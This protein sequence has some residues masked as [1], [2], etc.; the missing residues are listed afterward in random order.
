[1]S[2]WTATTKHAL[3][4]RWKVVDGGHNMHGFP[5]E[6]M[7]IVTEDDKEVIGCSEWMRAEREVFE[8]IV[9]IHNESLPN[10]T[11]ERPSGAEQ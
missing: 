5:C 1:M 10:R 3:T 2:H 6:D 11:N 4:T 7:S 9:K 8:H